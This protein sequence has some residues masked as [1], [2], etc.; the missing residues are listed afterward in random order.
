MLEVHSVVAWQQERTCTCRGLL[1]DG[2]GG[3][4]PEEEE[5]EE[6]EEEASTGTAQR[7][8]E[9]WKEDSCLCCL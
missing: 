5:E 4:G 9:G 7:V 1:Y 2:G 8:S 3:L 6:E